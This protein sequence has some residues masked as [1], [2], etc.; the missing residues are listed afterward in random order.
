MIF[1]KLENFIDF[2][3]IDVYVES[4]CN[5]VRALYRTALNR[6]PTPYLYSTLPPPCAMLNLISSVLNRADMTSCHWK[7][8]LC[9][10]ETYHEIASQYFKSNLTWCYWIFKEFEIFLWKKRRFR[11][12]WDSSPG[13]SIAGRLL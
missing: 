8:F 9:T 1:L 12:R 7:I 2:K 13:L 6:A 10:E 11:L 3:L 4:K 5:T